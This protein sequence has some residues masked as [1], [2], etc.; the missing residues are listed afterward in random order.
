M[1]TATVYKLHIPLTTDTLPTRLWIDNVAIVF[2]VLPSS[3]TSC[4]LHRI[5]GDAV[6]SQL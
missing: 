4:C 1:E 6:P 3:A 2:A 5:N